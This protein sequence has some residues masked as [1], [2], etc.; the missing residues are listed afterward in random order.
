M[1]RLFFTTALIISYSVLTFAQQKPPIAKVATVVSAEEAFNKLVARKG[2]KDGFLAVADPE[3]LVFKP[4]AKKI[5]D[6][7]GSIDKQPGTLSWKPKFARISANGDLAFTAGPYVYQNGKTDDDKVYGDYVSIWRNDGETGLKLLID[8]GIQHPEPEAES[9]TDF[10][11][12]DPA[13]QKAPSKE[14]FAG[15]GV[16]LQY[17][18]V[19]NS[20]LTKS[21][22]ATYKEFFSAEGRYYFPGFDPIVGVDKTMK[23]L[24]NEAIQ[25]NATT[26]S[27]GRST[28]SDLAYTYGTARINKGG[29]VSAYN[30]VRIWETDS[31]G[32]WNVLLEVFSA[33][34]K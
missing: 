29:I 3:G 32:Q 34:E 13:K 28:S 30:Y 11:E 33:V 10:K 12:P 20:S 17:D 2:I 8:L 24:A 23:F 27:A 4:N 6:F 26:V 31:K 7:Y 15:K 1:K 5:T 18:N 14:P 21:A 25:I 16:M 22:L 19:F 9:N